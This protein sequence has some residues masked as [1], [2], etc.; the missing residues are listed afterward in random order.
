MT[1]PHQ[2]HQP[3]H[4]NY[5]NATFKSQFYGPVDDGNYPLEK[6]INQ[7]LSQFY[8]PVDR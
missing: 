8:G 5:S 2:P 3:Y 1:G 7:L 6:N 4:I